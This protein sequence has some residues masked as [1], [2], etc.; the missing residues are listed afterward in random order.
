MNYEE[1]QQQDEAEYAEFMA[2]EEYTKKVLDL[3][4][5]HCKWQLQATEKEAKDLRWTIT[6]YAVYC[7]KCRSTAMEFEHGY[8][9]GKTDALVDSFR[10]G[11]KQ[12]VPCP[13]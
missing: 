9:C 2:F 13:F 1:Y 10:Q 12:N 7:P 3:Q 6:K 8:S 5:S 11:P 4:C